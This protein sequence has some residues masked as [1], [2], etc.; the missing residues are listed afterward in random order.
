MLFCLKS[1]PA[2]GAAAALGAAIAGRRTREVHGREAYL[3]YP[4]GIGNSKLT[5]TRIER[6]L[7]A[8]GTGRN[9]N[10]VRKID[11]LLNG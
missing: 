7:D 3:T 6:A 2:R 1:T 9:W 10:T 5:I 8:T 4:D 11:A